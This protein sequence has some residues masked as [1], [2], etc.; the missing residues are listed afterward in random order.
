M[1]SGWAAVLS[2]CTTARS[3][4]HKRHR[5]ICR[6][7]KEVRRCQKRAPA[8]VPA[9]RALLAFRAEQR[10]RIEPFVG[11]RRRRSC[12]RRRPLLGLYD[13]DDLKEVG[14]GTLRYRLLS[15]P[16]RLVRHARARVLKI[17]RT[18]PWKQAF[19]ASLQ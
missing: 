2:C 12:T 18:W 5:R 10:G 17:T 3:L 13:C 14:P 4:T 8:T 1:S 9:G 7:R 19:L 16:V 15:L 6:Y 11:S